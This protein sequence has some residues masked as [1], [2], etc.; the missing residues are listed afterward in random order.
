[1][2]VDA[3]QDEIPA[4]TLSKYSLHYLA[5]AHTNIVI[6]VLLGAE[7]SHAYFRTNAGYLL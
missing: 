6:M 3:L 1:M 5:F 2:F 7:V 4:K